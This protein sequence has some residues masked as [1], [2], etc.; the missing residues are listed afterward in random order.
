MLHPH[1]F[2]EF[3]HHF[4]IA[5]AK[6]GLD[7]IIFQ[8]TIEIHLVPVLLVPMPGTFSL[9]MLLPKF[10][11]TIGITSHRNSLGALQVNTGKDPVEDSK[12]QGP[13]IKGES[14]SC[15]GE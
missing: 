4:G 8:P 10:E 11:G 3:L 9:G 14:L 7:E 1:L 2:L 5:M 13:L 15:E 6:Q 12:H